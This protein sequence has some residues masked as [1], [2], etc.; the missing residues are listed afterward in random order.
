MTYILS[1]SLTASFIII[2]LYP[3]LYYT[4]NH[5]SHYKFN[6]CIIIT[7]ILVTVGMSL[8]LNKRLIYEDEGANENNVEM[9]ASMKNEVITFGGYDLYQDISISLIS[10]IVLIYIVGCFILFICEVFS[11]IRLFQLIVKS[12][13]K[14]HEGYVICRLIDTG[15]S[16]FSWGK[17]IFLQ[18]TDFENLSTEISY[19]I[20]LHEEAHITRYHW[21]DLILTDLF[22]M[23]LWYNPIV[24][25]VK[26]L[27]RLN[28]EFEADNAVIQTGID[29]R[30][31]QR[32]LVIKAM[33]K[34]K[35]HIADRFAMG[36]YD[37]RKRVLALNGTK[38]SVS[39]VLIAISGVFIVIISFFCLTTS[40]V[41][42]FI[43]EVR[44]SDSM[45][46]FYQHK[47]VNI[48]DIYIKKNIEYIMDYDV[49]PQFIG[50]EFALLKFLADNIKYPEN[51]MK[52]KTSGK[53]IV[54]I[55]ISKNGNVDNI[56]IDTGINPDLDDEALRVLSLIKNY[57]PGKKNGIDVNCHISI[58]ITFRLKN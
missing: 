30:Q 21:L 48:P 6:R 11:F 40:T 25:R 54:G 42:G 52:N 33:L 39:R 23:F 37:F 41:A 51:A 27:L 50:G 24:W 8:G 2:L 29:I 18:S 38:V 47:Q 4:V 15:I 55:D 56:R 10:I 22:C 16:P 45:K 17:Y 28:H 14:I 5:C 7:S 35:I 57:L 46:Q 49:A 26:K 58:P 13:K 12:E 1:Y 44:C 34:S 43:E 19:N 32:M 53:V 20:I 31:Y 9:L 36:K 3:V